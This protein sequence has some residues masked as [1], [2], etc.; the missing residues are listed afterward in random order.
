MVPRE[1][2]GPR[3]HDAPTGLRAELD[4]LAAR[5]HTAI[6]AAADTYQRLGVR[7]ALV[8][9]IAA[10]AYGRPRATKDIDFLVGE[11]AFDSLGLVISFKAGIPQEAC[12]VPIDNIPPH[13]EYL[14]LYERALNEA[15]ESDELGVLIAR[16]EMLAVTMLVDGRP[17]D[18]TAAVEMVQAGQLDLDKVERIVRPY[19]KLRLASARVRR[20]YEQSNE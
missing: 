10:G 12:G 6:H 4:H 8:G 14:D 15:V 9:G 7:Y 20:E 1:I 16:P 2:R 3:R 5:F 19:A 11:E 18:I 13:F 17:H